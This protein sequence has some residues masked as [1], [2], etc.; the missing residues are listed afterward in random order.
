MRPLTLIKTLKTSCDAPA[1]SEA[2][3]ES[4][5]LGPLTTVRRDS[6]LDVSQDVTGEM[7]ISGSSNSLSL[8]TSVERRFLIDDTYPVGIYSLQSSYDSCK[9]NRSKNKRSS[10]IS[11]SSR[12]SSI[13]SSNRRSTIS[14]W[15]GFSSKLGH[16]V[17]VRA[18][19]EGCHL[20]SRFSGAQGVFD[21][22]GSGDAYGVARTHT[23]MWGSLRAA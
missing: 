1:S 10:S 9:K 18:S 21:L 7:N 13:S 2:P 15:S 4:V 5:T 17:Q 12:C 14:R 6:L 8:S 23:G 20:S 11:S 3:F 16:E 19:G 22:R